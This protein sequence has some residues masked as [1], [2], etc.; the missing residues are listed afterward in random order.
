M[1]LVELVNLPQRSGNYKTV[2]LMLG[3]RERTLLVLGRYPVV[4][5]QESEFHADILRECLDAQGIAWVPEEWD[6]MK[7][8]KRGNSYCMVGAGNAH[9]DIGM[10]TIGLFGKSIGYRLE[11]TYRD[12]RESQTDPA[13]WSIVF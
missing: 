8:N 6:C 5:G 4:E 10:K 11:P 7:P 3:K 13:G 12:Y 2:Q 1:G 9:V